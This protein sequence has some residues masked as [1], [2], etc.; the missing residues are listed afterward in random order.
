MEFNETLEYDNDWLNVYN[1][2][3]S[4][5]DT[6]CDTTPLEEQDS[7]GLDSQRYFPSDDGIFAV[8]EI[9]KG[10]EETG[11]ACRYLQQDKLGVMLT[12]FWLAFKY[13]LQ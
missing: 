5:C 2:T 1:E 12:T 9:P 8:S 13:G 3:E 4:T 7:S 10:K 11:S 6:N